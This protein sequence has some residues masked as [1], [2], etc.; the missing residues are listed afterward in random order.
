[1]IKKQGL[2]VLTV[3]VA[4]SSCN[5]KI[6]TSLVKSYPPIDYRQE[7]V[8]IGLNDTVPDSSETLGVV[9][10]GDTGFSTNCGYDIVINIAKLEARKA[11]GNAIKITEHIPPS[12]MGSSCHRI[13]AKIIKIKNIESYKPDKDEGQEILKDVDYAILNVY[14]YNGAGALLNYDLYLGDSVICR[15]KNNFKTTL[16][17]KKDGLNTL[18]ARTETKAE[19]PI[20]IQFGKAYYLRCGVTIGFF[21]GH[22]HIELINWKTG[23]IEFDSFKAKNK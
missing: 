18:W 16:H 7:I 12:I 6:S 19:V 9:K 2:S 4:L 11:G 22:P 23:T 5:P 3:L 13:T 20:N 15:V 1:M 17:I 14:R 8:V 21:V 10:I